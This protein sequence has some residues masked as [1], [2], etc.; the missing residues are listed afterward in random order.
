[1]VS[2]MMHIRPHQT[3]DSEDGM[4]LKTI[5]DCLGFQQITSLSSSTALTMPAAGVIGQK[6]K[7]AVVHCEAQAVRWRDDGT[8]PTASV[9]MRPT[10]GS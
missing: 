4:S 3:F 6:P 1:M 8:A 5:T 7:I 9:G 2:C 10:V